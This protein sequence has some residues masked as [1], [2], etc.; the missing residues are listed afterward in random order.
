MVV[1][2]TKLLM[3]PRSGKRSFWWR[4]GRQCVADHR[5]VGRIDGRGPDNRRE[6]DPVAVN[7]IHLDACRRQGIGLLVLSVMPEHARA[8]TGPTERA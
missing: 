4:I 2:A 6:P 5:H 8:Y 7:A 1:G 3:Q